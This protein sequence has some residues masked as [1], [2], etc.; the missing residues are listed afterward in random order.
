MN[1]FFVN[2]AR[3]MCEFTQ[4]GI[5]GGNYDPYL[6]AHPETARIL[7]DM[8]K[9]V[10]SVLAIPYWSGVPFAFGPDRFVKYQLEPTITVPPLPT[11]P[12]N[13]T[14]LAADLAE[15]LKAGDVTFR[16]C[17]QFRTNPE[18]EPLD[19]AT[20]PWPE[21]IS[22]PVHLADLILP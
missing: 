13:P 10:A 3:G 11:P 5:I 1:V 17:A 19:M 9:P 22:P 4:A 21:S 18:T 16:F 8:A 15:R 2:T 12:A 20:V 14:Y 7:N 6:A